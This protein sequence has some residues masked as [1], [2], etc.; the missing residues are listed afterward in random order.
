MMFGVLNFKWNRI[1]LFKQTQF[2][3]KKNVNRN[4]IKTFVG[5][6]QRLRRSRA[7]VNVPI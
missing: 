5:K 3:K 7:D 2:A 4:F 6:L 1:E